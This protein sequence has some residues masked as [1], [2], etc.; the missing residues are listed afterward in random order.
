MPKPLLILDTGPII[1]LCAFPVQGNHAYIH[2][3]LLYAEIAISAGVAQEALRNPPHPDVRIL[4][5][6]L[7]K[8]QIAVLPVPTEPTILELA[9]SKYIGAGERDIIHLGLQTPEASIV[10]DDKSAVQIGNR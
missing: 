8:Q 3:I 1:S 6:L 10:I 5:P 9:Y 7:D 4:R 2:T